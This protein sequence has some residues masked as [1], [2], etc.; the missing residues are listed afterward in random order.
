MTHETT[1]EEKRGLVGRT[2]VPWQK[3]N[4]LPWFAEGSFIYDAKLQLVTYADTDSDLAEF[5][6]K[7]VNNHQSL[8]EALR[9]VI[10]KCPEPA[11]GHE[12]DMINIAEQA[13]TKA[14]AT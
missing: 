9:A 10:E 2:P 3:R 7:A 14:E 4:P 8:V 12:I 13:L 11:I 6:V 5:I 1:P